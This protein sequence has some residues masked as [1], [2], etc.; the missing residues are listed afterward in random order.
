[1]KKGYVYLVGAGPGNPKLI[2]IKGLECIAKADVL[3]YDRLISAHLLN[4]AKPECE[5]IYVG[6]SPKAQVRTQ[7]EINALLVEKGLAGKTVTRLKGGDPFVFGR[8]G[9]EAEALAEAGI[10]FEIVPGVTSAVAVPAYAGIPV[11][12]RGLTSSFTVITGHERADKENSNIP[13]KN[14]AEA[15]NTLIFLMGMENLEL[16]CGKLLEHGRSAKTPVGII[17][18]GTYSKQRVI[19]GELGGIASIAR[20]KRLENPAVIVVG[21]VVSLREKL[22]WLERRPL[23]GQTIIVTR[24][25][26][27]AAGLSQAI[28][29]LGGEALE[30]P[31][32]KITEPADSQLLLRAM[33]NLDSL[34]WLIFTSVNGVEAFFAELGRR[35]KD[36]RELAGVKIAAIGPVTQAA[37][38]KRG[39]SVSFV[40]EE[41]RNEKIAEGLAGKLIPGE[42]VLLARAQEA[43]GLLP[44]ALAASGADVW[45]VPVYRTVPGEAD[46]DR[47]RDLLE[48]KEIDGVTF[49]SPSTVSHFLRLLD[50]KKDLLSKVKLCSIG[51]VTSAALQ[52][53]GLPVFSE[54]KEYTVE[55]LVKAMIQ[56]PA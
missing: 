36:I 10:P 9:E 17:E 28:E 42:R 25:S 54:A 34:S 47:L 53:M 46:K 2:T 26:H 23:F 44:Q 20:A 32:I 4:Q 24:A 55:G 13:W 30:F 45:D 43:S 6:K 35:G 12:H 3:I 18:W 31:V 11:T 22:N 14:L 50:G 37:L 21:E 19:S 48:N 39:L 27:Q 49:T 33:E 7:E 51:P 5:K 1:M 38:T 56:G 16:I 15:Q 8:G 41:F 40:P 52:E 29:E